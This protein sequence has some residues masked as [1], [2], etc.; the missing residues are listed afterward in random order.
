MINYNNTTPSHDREGQGG[1]ELW[2]AC[3]SVPVSKMTS[4]QASDQHYVIKLV[5]VGQNVH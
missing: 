1:L 5:D 2:W 4:Q 3:D